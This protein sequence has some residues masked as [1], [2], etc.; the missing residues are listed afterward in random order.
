M[1]RFVATDYDITINGTDLSSNIASVSLDMTTNEVETTS[2]GNGGFVSRIGGLK[3]ASVTLSFHQ[4]FGAAS[5][6]Q[7]LFPL[8]GQEATVVVKPTSGAVSATNPSFT[9][10]ALCTELSPVS[11]AVGDLATLEVTWPLASGSGV[12]EGTA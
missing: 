11:G 10:V 3:D 2:F 6:H 1:A 8:H 7:T 9:M 4:D 12:V 5:V